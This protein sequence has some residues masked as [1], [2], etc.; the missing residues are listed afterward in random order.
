MPKAQRLMELWMAV[1][2]KRS[3]TV[4]EL[5]R[6]FGVSA[7][8]ILRDLQ[9]LSEIGV[10]L[11]SEPGPHGGYRVLDSRVLPP[12]AFT[13]EEAVAV[14]FAAHALRHYNSLPFEAEMASAL[15][16]FAARLP[17]DVQEGIE[18]M[19]KRVDFVVPARLAES[20]HLKT[21]LDAAV[22]RDVLSIR[23]P[24]GESGGTPKQR[25]IVPIGIFAHSGLWYCPAYCFGNRDIRL[26]RCDRMLSVEPVQSGAAPKQLEHVD[27]TNRRFFRQEEQETVELLIELDRT[28]VQAFESELWA[29]S[30]LHVRDDGT[31]WV[32]GEYPRSDLPF[33]ARFL[34]GIG[35]G[36]TA[37]RPPELVAG[38]KELATDVV[39]K[40]E[41]T[42]DMEDDLANP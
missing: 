36:A 5:A 30:L 38:V 33:L 3:F 8:T 29:S 31:G 11:Y 18:K 10:P 20:P 13:E 32:S 9:E 28:G 24:S 21:L 7:R 26:F 41:K 14:F 35:R 23:Y 16:K 17:V 12:V 15:R 22:R 19:K 34:L 4:K 27:L 1:N 25:E 42:D 39:R 6:E 40:Y 2:R 37:V